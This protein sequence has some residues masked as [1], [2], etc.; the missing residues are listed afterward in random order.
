[1][2]TATKSLLAMTALTLLTACPNKEVAPSATTPASAPV[3]ETT[4]TTV[5]I[6]QVSAL[7]GAVAHIGKDN[8]RGAILAIDDLNAE[9][10]VIG[11][12]KIHFELVS[13]DDAGDPKMAKQVAQ[14]LI[15]SG[16]V[17]VVGHLHSGTTIP[18]SQVYSEAGIPQ[19]SPASTSPLYTAQGFKTAFRVIA[20]D[21]AQGE[22]LANF[23]VDQLKAKRIV[24]IDDRAAYGQG[25]A[26][27]FERA[28]KAKGGTILKREYTS[29]TANDFNAIITSLSSVNPDVV[30]FGGMDSQGAPL[31]KQMKRQG[32]KAVM[33]G[34]DALNSDSFIKLAGDAAEGQ[35]SSICGLPR[36]KMPGFADFNKRFE[37]K[38]KEGI[39]IFAP[40]E[41]DAVKVLVDAM[42]RADSTD[43][44]V[45]LPKL[46]STQYKGITGDI[47]F[48]EKGD[49]TTKAVTVYQVKNGK[50]VV[51]HT[52]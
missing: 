11:N 13:E 2:I 51:V 5:K 46:A 3:A 4:Q 44:K 32:M 23:A 48:D 43:P 41:Y 16:V 52:N 6:G 17:G 30:F 19:I 9:N 21:L 29:T 1:M 20:N 42:K 33:L 10:L 39:Q 15:E 40:Y 36:D 8:E 47:S 45:Y 26:D 49:L 31:A 37:D 12:K 34:G 28:V 27:E 24:I 38:F 14:R 7:S 50:W 25:L 18:A 22:A 35:Y